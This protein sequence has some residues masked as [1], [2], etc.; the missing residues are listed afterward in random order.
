[1]Q[2]TSLTYPEHRLKEVP[3]EVWLLDLGSAVDKDRL[4][5]ITGPMLDASELHRYHSFRHE[6]ARNLFLGARFLSRKVL[7]NRLG[8]SPEM[9]AFGQ[10]TLG[11]PYISEPSH[12]ETLN[13]NLSHSGSLV[14]CGVSDRGPVG[15]DVEA[16]D[17]K[18]AA[19]DIAQA[20]FGEEE[21]KWVRAN[22]HL[23][24]RRFLAL[25]TLK[26]AC[27]KTTGEGLRGGLERPSFKPCA[28][29]WFR[30]SDPTLPACRLLF[31][32]P[33]YLLAVC[34]CGLER[35]KPNVQWVDLAKYPLAPFSV[36]LP[37]D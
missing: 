3:V 10:N 4:A 31:P 14:V 24:T 17:C 26:E 25:W 8:L 19:E 6:G 13:F 34:G 22:P 18:V 36:G 32:K 16:L 20:H 30:A 37:P 9:I 7:A 21:A 33:G 23:A 11:K 12:A 5:S 28:G 27:L 15:V 29:G 1:M 2:S 35:Q